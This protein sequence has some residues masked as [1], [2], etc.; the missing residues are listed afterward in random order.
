MEESLTKL[1]LLAVI[2][3]A[4]RDRADNLATNAIV[5]VSSAVV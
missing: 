4:L 2:W 5:V 1:S 3:Q